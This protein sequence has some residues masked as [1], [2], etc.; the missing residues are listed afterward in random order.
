MSIS[1]PASGP[2]SGTVSLEDYA[3]HC[4]C[5]RLHFSLDIK[6]LG[7]PVLAWGSG[8]AGEGV[9]RANPLWLEG[10]GE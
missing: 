4:S 1:A 10:E 2:R 5:R 8:Q 7:T 6:S 9:R 3:E